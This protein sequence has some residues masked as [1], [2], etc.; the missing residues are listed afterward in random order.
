M[1]T[2]TSIEWTER[3]WNPT[4]GCTKISPGC[5]NCYAELMARR[6]QAMGM[7]GYENG[8]SLTLLPNRLSEPIGRKKPASFFVNSMSDLFHDA[9]PD[10]FLDQVIEVIR[11]T[12]WHRY[13]VLTK[14]SERAVAYFRRHT[15]PENMWMG[16]TVENKGHGVPRIRELVQIGAAVRFLSIEPLLEDLGHVDFSGID[17]VIVGGESGHKA[18]IVRPEW[19]TSI[20]RLCREQAVPFFFKQ[21]GTWGADG[22]KRAKKLNG[23]LL[24]GRTWS[25]MPRESRKNLSC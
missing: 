9:V 7:P 11:K 1:G 2:Q 6:L 12:P 23:R 21:W 3:T 15:P 22:L 24:Q 25:E 17:W 5:K 8:F 19:I 16:V 18:R 4:V 10:S 14:R 20:Q 13:Q